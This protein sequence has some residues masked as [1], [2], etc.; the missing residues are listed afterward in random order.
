MVG[1]GGEGGR[2]ANP[3][4][5]AV[6]LDNNRVVAL[7]ALRK[8]TRSGAVGRADAGQTERAFWSPSTT[9]ASLPSRPCAKSPH[10]VRSRA[11]NGRRAR[12]RIKSKSP[13]TFA[14]SLESVRVTTC[15]SEKDV[16]ESA[17][18]KQTHSPAAKLGSVRKS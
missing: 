7:V 5:V 8:E 6:A 17:P 10:H 14:Q 1:S 15:L 18:S 4:A 12:A 3:E 2:G 16:P 13:V 9:I 11:Q